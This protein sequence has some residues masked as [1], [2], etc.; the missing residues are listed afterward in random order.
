MNSK[1]PDRHFVPLFSQKRIHFLR[2][3]VLKF[4]QKSPLQ[5]EVLNTVAK[6]TAILVY[7]GHTRNNYYSTPESNKQNPLGKLLDSSFFFRHKF[8]TFLKNHL[9]RA[10]RDKF[11]CH[12][13]DDFS[14]FFVLNYWLREFPWSVIANCFELRCQSKKQMQKCCTVCPCWYCPHIDQILHRVLCS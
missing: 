3:P 12:F 13:Q 10:Q 6:D 5:R 7:F 4:L 2:H 9:S 11:H 14:G 8:M 1:S